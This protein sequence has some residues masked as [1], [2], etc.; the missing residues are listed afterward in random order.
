M[1]RHH[2]ESPHR[3]LRPRCGGVKGENGKFENGTAPWRRRDS[4]GPD[5]QPC[6]RLQTKLSGGR[7]RKGQPM[8]TSRWSSHTEEACPMDTQGLFVG[9]R[10]SEGSLG[11]KALRNQSRIPARS[12]AK[13]NS[14]RIGVVRCAR[15]VARV[16]KKRGRLGRERGGY[17]FQDLQLV[18]R[19]IGSVIIEATRARAVIE[20]QATPA[21]RLSKE[22]IQQVVIEM[23]VVHASPMNIQGQIGGLQELSSR[24]ILERHLGKDLANQFRWNISDRGYNGSV[25]PNAFPDLVAPSLELQNCSLQIMDLGLQS[26]DLCITEFYSVRSTGDEIVNGWEV[27]FKG[28]VVAGNRVR[29]ERQPRRWCPAAGAG[30]RHAAESPND[31]SRKERPAEAAA[32]HIYTHP[33]VQKAEEVEKS[34]SL[35]V[36]ND[37]DNLR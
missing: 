31:G 30:L 34:S 1:A 9:L 27:R 4:K 6:T 2:L 24:W 11:R 36:Q 32:K 10:D 28:R 29:K 13:R 12:R 15:T 35:T 22:Q 21:S 18:H 25:V 14:S 37:A 26:T 7:C 19:G 5:A 16:E 3:I 20:V 33:K 17:R 8:Q 23:M